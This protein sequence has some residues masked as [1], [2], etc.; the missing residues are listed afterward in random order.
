MEY[1]VAP[2]AMHPYPVCM[3]CE[4]DCCE[5]Y[6]C[7]LHGRKPYASCDCPDLETTLS[8]DCGYAKCEP[9][10]LTAYWRDGEE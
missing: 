1:V 9:D 5:F 3:D 7:A 8:P 6:V 10:L 4:M 2:V